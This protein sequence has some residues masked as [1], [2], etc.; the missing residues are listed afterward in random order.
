MDGLLFKV[1]GVALISAMLITLLRKMGSEQ[2]TMLKLISGVAVATLSMAAISPVIE[3]VREVAAMSE[4]VT[5][6]AELM[7]RTLSVAITTHICA[8]VCRDCGE[9]SLASYVE[10]G[11][12][13]EIILLS[14]PYIK[15]VIN[16]AVGMI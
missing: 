12:K 14:L 11:G 9:G 5:E 10:M 6:Y 8:G 16:S 13:V 4:S 7:L 2:A 15:G 1:C 3:F